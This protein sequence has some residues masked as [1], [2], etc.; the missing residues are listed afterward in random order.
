MNDMQHTS[1]ALY[2]R[3]GDRLLTL[4]DAEA[5]GYGSVI[6]LKQRIRRNQIKGYKAGTL[7]LV[8]K[9]D[10]SRPRNQ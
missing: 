10:L 7:W 9:K 8:R 1:I 4:K 6:L 3:N 5:K 2:N